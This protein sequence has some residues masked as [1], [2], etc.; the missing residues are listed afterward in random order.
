M[1]TRV[2]RWWSNDPVFQPH[3]SPYNS[4]DGNPIM[5]KDPLGDQVDDHY[6]DEN[7]KYIFSDNNGTNN[8]KLI[9]NKTMNNIREKH[10]I[11]S[12]TFSGEWYSSKA[13][14]KEVAARS[15]SLDKINFNKVNPKILSNIV[16]H[17]NKTEL[18]SADKIKAVKGAI[19]MLATLEGKDGKDS[20]SRGEPV[21]QVGYTISGAIANKHFVDKW[22]IVNTLVHEQAHFE[23]H[24]KWN[25]T[26]GAWDRTNVD[27]SEGAEE[28]LK[29]Y[30]AQVNHWSFSYTTEDYKKETVEYMFGLVKLIADPKIKEK[31][32]KK[33][34][35]SEK[36]KKYLN[37]KD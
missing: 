35:K 1:D 22:N 14:L 18:F 11:K 16:D 37:E 8:I 12:N 24:F 32:Y 6:F 15:R 33:I 26:K 7:G 25:P 36:L 30:H 23:K 31:E 2:A 5:Y 19:Y 3:Q 4:M 27:G 9:T 28:H 20:Y 21:I 29:A 17:F 34:A 10:G 13:F